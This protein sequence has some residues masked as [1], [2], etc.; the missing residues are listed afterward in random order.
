MSIQLVIGPFFSCG[1]D[2]LIPLLD[3]L[4][5]KEESQCRIL[6]ARVARSAEQL[7][8]VPRVGPSP[9]S[10]DDVIHIH[11]IQVFAFEGASTARARY[12]S[13]TVVPT[14]ELL[15][16]V[17]SRCDSSGGD[18]FLFV[19]R[20]VTVQRDEEFP[21]VAFV[22]LHGEH[23]VQVESGCPAGR[24]RLRILDEKARV[25]TVGLATTRAFSFSGARIGTRP[26]ST[27]G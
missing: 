11:Q 23:I 26:L 22:W 18:T 15:S 8:V 5:L 3:R 17:D 1:S 24:G 6:L 20:Q 9:A 2:R 10:G 21:G 27:A 14:E 13:V 4:S 16:D 12:T 25:V 19:S 7:D